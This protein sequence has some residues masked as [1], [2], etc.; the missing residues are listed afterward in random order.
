MRF[1]IWRCLGR[2]RGV[3]FRLPGAGQGGVA[4]GAYMQPSVICTEDVHIAAVNKQP[5]ALA[6]TKLPDNIKLFQFRYGIIDSFR[7]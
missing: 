5:V 3:R 4:Y 1:R 6:L 7:A 2:L